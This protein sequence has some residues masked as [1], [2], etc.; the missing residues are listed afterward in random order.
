MPLALPQLPSFKNRQPLDR[1][2]DLEMDNEHG[3]GIKK[4]ADSQ[5]DSLSKPVG[6]LN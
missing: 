4:I 6:S 5:N 1:E 3:D 2:R